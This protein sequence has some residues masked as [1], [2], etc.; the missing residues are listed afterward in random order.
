MASSVAFTLS[1]EEKEV[2]LELKFHD[3]KLVLPEQVI[4]LL[5]DNE[6]V[7]AD[8]TSTDCYITY[9]INDLELGKL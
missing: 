9:T 5:D 1:C 4:E 2:S 3:D 8:C 7:V 6:M